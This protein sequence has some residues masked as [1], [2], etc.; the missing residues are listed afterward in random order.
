MKTQTL[1]SLKFL[2]KVNP[3]LGSQTLHLLT[4]T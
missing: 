4:G 3:N 1:K 2:E